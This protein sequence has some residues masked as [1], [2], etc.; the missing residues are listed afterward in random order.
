MA[1]QIDR[2]Y[3]IRFTRW[4]RAQH[5]IMIL[6]FVGLLIT[7]LPQKWPEFQVSIQTVDLLGGIFA[8]RWLHRALGIALTLL[9]IAHLATVTRYL[10]FERG[11]PTMFVNRRD[12]TDAIEQLQ[13]YR[14]QR[15][16]EPSFGRYDFRQK[17]EYWGLLMG[18]MVMV[19]SGFVLMYP[20]QISRFLP[21]ELIPAAKVMHSYEAMLAMLI[22]VVWHM[23]SAIFNPHAFPLDRT[24]FTGKISKDRMREEHP[25]EYEE[26]FGSSGVS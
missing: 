16:N 5:L 9:A 3:V 4:Q 23:Y 1:K 15:E 21:A 20:M 7:G 8:T 14:G 22:V 25:L 24:I 19:G 11:K 18:T 26:R 10:F 2:D 13:Y 6:T 12:F 17:F